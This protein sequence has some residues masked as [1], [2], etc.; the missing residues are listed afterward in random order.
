MADR[1]LLAIVWGE[2]SALK[3]KDGQDATLARLHAIVGKLAAAAMR[4]GLD[5]QLARKPAPGAEDSDFNSYVAM[6]SIVNAVDAGTWRSDV[7]LPARAVLWEV[8]ESGAPPRDRAPPQSAAWILDADG[9][10][11]VGW[12][13]LFWYRCSDGAVCVPCGN[14]SGYCSYTPR[15]PSPCSVYTRPWRTTIHATT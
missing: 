4:R 11:R 3:P 12:S 5:H 14:R 8:T 10:G 1:D 13:V 6:R 9:C 2:T 7:E 15:R